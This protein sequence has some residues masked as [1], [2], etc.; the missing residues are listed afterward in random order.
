MDQ[1]VQDQLS[2]R[3]IQAVFDIVAEA[4]I[5]KPPAKEET[6]LERRLN[7]LN[8]WLMKNAFLGFITMLVLTGILYVTRSNPLIHAIQAIGIIVSF[9]GVIMQLVIIASC[10]PFFLEIKNSPYAP[11]L[12]LV[13]ASSEFDLKFVNRLALCDEAAVRYVL[14]YYKH[15]RTC[16]EKRGSLLSGSIEKIG[17]FPALATLAVLAASID[18]IPNVSRWTEMLVPLILAFYFLNLTVFGML[19]RKDR[20]ITLLEFSIASR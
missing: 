5:A 9:F 16:M 8:S 19:Q 10:I 17:L 2:E 4:T 7:S 18:K 12:R 3:E 1:R 11:F 14:A 15:E 6:N 13:K 20:V